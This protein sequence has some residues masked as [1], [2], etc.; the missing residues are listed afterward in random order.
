MALMPD[1][2]HSRKHC[3][4]H[5]AVLLTCL[6][7]VSYSIVVLTR[8]YRLEREM[9]AYKFDLFLLSLSPLTDSMRGAVSRK[10]DSN[11]NNSVSNGKQHIYRRCRAG[12]L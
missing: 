1:T 12:P 6:K 7:R 8:F 4:T 9:P 11:K 10:H 3:D 5:E 2:W